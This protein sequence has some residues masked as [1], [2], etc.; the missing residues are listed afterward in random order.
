MSPAVISLIEYAIGMVVFVV[1]T[2]V[3]FRSSRD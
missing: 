3:L 1:L 2:F